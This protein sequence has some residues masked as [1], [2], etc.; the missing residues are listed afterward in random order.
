[1]KY[2]EEIGTGIGMIGTLVMAVATLTGI[3][4]WLYLW[5]E[6]MPV[7]AAMWSGFLWF[8]SMIG[9]GLILVLIGLFIKEM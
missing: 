5:A 9:A 2:A 3:G 1:M 6:S 7:G 8:L 4:R